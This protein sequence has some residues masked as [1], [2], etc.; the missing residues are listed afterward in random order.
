MKILCVMPVSEQEKKQ[1]SLAAG[2]NTVDYITNGFE[3]AASA[4]DIILGNVPAECI[5]NNRNLKWLQ[6]NSAGV[7]PYIKE[8]VLPEGCLLTNATG[9]Y[10]LAISEHMLGM[11]LSIIKRLHLYRDIQK[12]CAWQD[13]G[14][15]TSVYGSKVLVVGMGDIGSRF[16][17]LCKAM[18]ATVTGVRRTDLTPSPY[19]DEIRLTAE[20]DELLP[21]AD[22]V[23]LALP[24]T[25]ETSGIINAQRIAK[26]KKGAMLL[27]VG[28]GSAV[29]TEALCDALESGRLGGAGLDVT[30]PEPL[31]P[32]HRLWKIPTAVITPHVSGGFH[33]DAT[34]SAIAE[35][36]AY[37][38]ERFI[39]KSGELKNIIDFST[40]YRKI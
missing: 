25:P 1:I 18:G 19:A 11:Y 31:P 17:M 15:V 40:G 33:L 34:R 21:G 26:M 36:F 29:D 28:R 10:G 30:D 20:L 12:E 37:N 35:I 39:N 27:N 13:L 16:A 8:G 5:Q 4:A 3:E 14:P 9:G 6:A 2:E 38:L 7:E 32:N 24:G 23:A 22:A